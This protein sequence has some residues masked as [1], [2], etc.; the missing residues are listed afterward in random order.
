[1][2]MYSFKNICCPTY[3]LDNGAHE[4]GENE[5]GEEHHGA[6]NSHICPNASDLD[7]MK[8]LTILTL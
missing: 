7:Q 2:P 8:V 6:D 1:M 5:L 4:G 3:T